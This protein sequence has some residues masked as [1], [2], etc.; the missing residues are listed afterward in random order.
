MTTGKVNVYGHWRKYNKSVLYNLGLLLGFPNETTLK[1]EVS[2]KSIRLLY[3]WN[4]YQI[5]VFF[6]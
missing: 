5:E 3:Q 2:F 1:D 4:T 6:Q